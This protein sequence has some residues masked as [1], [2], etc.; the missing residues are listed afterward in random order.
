[1]RFYNKLLS[2]ASFPVMGYMLTLV[3]STIL[4][5]LFVWPAQLL[6]NRIVPALFGLPR[7]TFW[8]MVGLK[9]LIT[10]FFGIRVTYGRV[11]NGWTS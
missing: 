7:I 10:I 5:I 6:W 1:M 2:Y 8:Q 9:L 4:A 3:L 11:P